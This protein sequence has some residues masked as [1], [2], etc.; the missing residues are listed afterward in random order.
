MLIRT[1]LCMSL[2]APLW[3]CHSSGITDIV[4]TV[5]PDMATVVHV[6]WTTTEAGTGHVEFGASDAYGSSSP[7]DTA[8]TS[9]RATLYGLT[10]DTVCHFAVVS[11]DA[12]S[13]DQTITTDP[14]PN[15]LP[16][17]EEAVPIT[18]PD[19]GPL[20]LTSTINL[21][22]D[23]SVVEVINTAGAPVWYWKIDGGVVSARLMS[24]GSGVYYIAE[25]REDRSANKLVFVTFEGVVT[26]IPIPDV[27]HDVIEG[28][29][30]GWVTF[31]S[32]Y[33]EMDG[34]NVAGDEI[35]EVSADGS[36]RVVWN[37]FENLPVVENGGWETSQLEDAV[38]WTHANGLVY[39]P[40]DDS[41]VVSFYFTRQV[42][43]I[44]RL[45]GATDWILGGLESDFVFT[46]GEDFGPQHAPELFD[47][48]LRVFDNRGSSYGSRLAEYALDASTGTAT[49]TWSWEYPGESWTPV[50]G[51][52]HRF[53]DGGA[54]ATWGITG[55]ILVISPEGEIVGDLDVGNNLTVGQVSVLSSMYPGG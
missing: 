17:F 21:E 28:P 32:E 46:D 3:A 39:D 26:E 37:A 14:L 29:D 31:V 49:L 20:L 8:G 2:L 41:Y 40:T 4:A 45:T 38:D 15:G 23:H 9:H 44:D 50:L 43:K 35:V 5:D 13:D 12:T 47:G 19:A 18:D 7:E 11:G 54:I 33:R 36:M 42:V 34:T 10:A 1:F 25:D 51:D 22:A 16:V 27:H 24:D 6:S 53:E 55:E 30:G 52:M 48:G